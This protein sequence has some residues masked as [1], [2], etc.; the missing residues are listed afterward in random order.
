MMRMGSPNFANAIF[1]QCPRSLD[2]KT[3]ILNPLN[4]HQGPMGSHEPKW[5]LLESTK[6]L[7]A[8]SEFDPPMIPKGS[9]GEP[10]G[11]QNKSSVDPLESMMDQKSI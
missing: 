8:G 1:F 10:K 9:P 11:F 7:K 6:M 3:P 2:P 5:P 4:T